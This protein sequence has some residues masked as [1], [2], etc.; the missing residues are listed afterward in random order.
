[1]TVNIFT[2]KYRLIETVR[3]KGCKSLLF[4]SNELFHAI[5]TTFVQYI[6]SQR[7][8]YLIFSYFLIS[9]KNYSALECSTIVS[10]LAKRIT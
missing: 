1:M 10:N 7:C 5:L 4:Y 9:Q 8:F 6:E 3:L 2:C